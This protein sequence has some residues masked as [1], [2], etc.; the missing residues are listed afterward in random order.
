LATTGEP[1]L[2]RGTRPVAGAAL[3]L[4]AASFWATFGIFAKHLYDAGFAPLE[5]ASVRAAVGFAGFALLLAPR[6]LVR[7]SAGAPTLVSGSRAAGARSLGF[8]AAYGILGYALFTLVFF[9]ALE[10]LDVSIAVALLYTA[11]AFVM[12]MSALLWREHV[13][14]ARL[15]AL[16]LVLAGVILVT[17]AAGTLLG[18]ATTLPPIALALGVGAGATYGL[19]TMFSKVATHRYGP[20]ASLFWSFAFAA[21]AL[22]IAAPPWAPFLRAPEHAVALIALGIVPTLVPYALYLRGLREL[23]ASTAAM[24]A[25]VEPVIAALLAAVLLHERLDALQLAGMAMVVTAAVLLARQAAAGP[26]RLRGGPDGRD[27]PG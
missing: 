8:F 10:R 3:V 20:R 9:A 14:P 21:L 26:A 5:L 16:G 18:G 24:L 17:G 11:P 13:G 25:S 15:V 6:M 27:G 23:P 19:Y 2:H 7:P 12:L 1:A 22:G 4:G